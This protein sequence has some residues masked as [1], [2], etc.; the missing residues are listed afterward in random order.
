MILGNRRDNSIVCW[1]I[2]NTC[3]ILGRFQRICT[4]NQRISFDIDPI[5]GRYL[6][7]GQQNGQILCFDLMTPPDTETQYVPI[8]HKFNGKH[9]RY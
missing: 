3:N 1:D 4:T 7:S 8:T 6:I 2:R 9:N 5:G